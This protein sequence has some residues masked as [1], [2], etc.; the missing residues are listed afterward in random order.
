MIGLPNNVHLEAVRVGRRR[1]QGDRLHQAARPQRVRRP[2]RW[3]ASCARRASCTA[4]PRPRS[5]RPDVMR[6]REMIE[7]G[8]DRP[9]CSRCAPARR[10]PARTRRTSGTARRP[11][12]ARCST[13]A[14]TRSR[15]RATSSARRTR[16]RGVRLGRDDRAPRQDVGRGQRGRAAQVA[17]A[18]SSIT[19]ASLVGQGRHGAA[20]RDL[21]SEGRILTD[22]HGHA[23]LGVRRA[24]RR[25]TSWRR[26]TPT[27][28]GSSPIPDEARDYG[29]SRGDAALR[30][31]L[32]EP[33]PSRARRSSTATSSTACWTPAIAR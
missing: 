15:R 22:I 33:A 29:Y 27:P 19:E 5:S 2:P 10:T 28:A 20:Q 23:R 16:Q 31:V 3:C 4:T 25:A 13:W 17:T 6:A 12:A 18:A 1:G 32:R 8:R 24:S 14:A 21:G 30:R 9:T 7:S 26:P 11:A